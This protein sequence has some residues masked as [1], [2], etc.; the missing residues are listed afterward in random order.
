MTI[1]VT[2]CEAIIVTLCE[3]II[4]TLREVAGSMMINIGIIY[5]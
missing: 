2:L 3:A 1:I 5:E 4:V